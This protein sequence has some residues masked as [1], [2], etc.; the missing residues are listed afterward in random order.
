MANLERIHLFDMALE[1]NIPSYMIDGLLD[2][3]LEHCPAGSFLTAILCNDLRQ[4][5]NKADETNK[6]LIWEYVY[7]LFNHAPMGCWGSEERVAEWLESGRKMREAA[8]PR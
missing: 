2:Y 8:N 5:C 3:I 1:C 6:H 4:A 7:F